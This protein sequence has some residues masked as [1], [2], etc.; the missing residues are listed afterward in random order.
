ME[1]EIIFECANHRDFLKTYLASRK[2]SHG[3]RHLARQAGFKSSALVSML[4]KG[5]RRLTIRSAELLAKALRLKGKQKSL[6]LAFARLDSGRSEKEKNQAREEILKLKSYRPEFQMSAK[7]YSF[8][9]TWYYPVVFALLQNAPKNLSPSEIA[10]HLGRGVSAAQ[11]KQAMEDLHFL[12]LVAR[13]EQGRVRPVNAAISTAEDVRDLAVG[14]YH[15]NMLALAEAALELPLAEREFNGLT[16]T[17]PK[18][19]VPHVKEKIRRLRTELNELLARETEA[20]DV[21]QIN[22]QF[23]PLTEGLERKES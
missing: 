20:A 6:F 16:V 3:M 15:R 11:V 18:R 4:V 10:A 13:D 9:A 5:E 17:V 2:S 12:G 19:L 23:F 8:L 14:K 1:T 7:Q 22:M 21:Y